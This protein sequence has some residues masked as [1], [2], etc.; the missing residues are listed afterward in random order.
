MN[1]E[2]KRVIER[3]RDLDKILIQMFAY[4]Q[5]EVFDTGTLELYHKS[6]E[7]YNINDIRGACT[8][9]IKS[10]KWFPKISE[11]IDLLPKNHIPQLESTATLQAH[12]ILERVRMIG[13]S[14][15]P[16][17]WS[18]PITNVLM[19]SRWT[20]VSVCDMPEDKTVWFV[21]EFIKSYTAISEE[22]TGSL[23]LIAPEKLRILASG[24]FKGVGDEH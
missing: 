18:D 10:S 19:H 20:W 21:K 6:L 2:R 3:K 5:V 11:I 15:S 14:G 4:Y 8:A 17:A 23:M 1:E 7:A 9:H 12:Y 24:L 16:P 22:P 13:L